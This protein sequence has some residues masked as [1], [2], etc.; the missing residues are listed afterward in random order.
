M[1]IIIKI[2][3]ILPGIYLFIY[4][5]FQLLVWESKEIHGPSF[6]LFL[7]FTIKNNGDVG[8]IY[9]FGINNVIVE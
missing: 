7:I 5:V 3:E 9:F 8:L 2:L 4:L 1:E 6:R